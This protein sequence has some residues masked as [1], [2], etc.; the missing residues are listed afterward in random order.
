MDVDSLRTELEKH[1]AKNPDAHAPHGFRDRFETAAQQYQAD[2]ETIPKA[3]LEAELQQIRTEAEAAANAAGMRDE[4]PA[5]AEPRAEAEPARPT[6]DP[7]ERAAEPAQIGPPASNAMSYGIAIVV[8]VIVI[9][10][11]WYFFRR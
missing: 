9:A 6:P 1:L 10:G 11:A 2:E 3:A 7:V 5:A 8:A 4:A